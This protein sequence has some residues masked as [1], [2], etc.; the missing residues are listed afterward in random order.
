MTFT[1]GF[2]DPTPIMPSL[3]GFSVHKIPNYSSL[4]ATSVS[5]REL[6]ACQQAYP[7][8]EFN[9]TYEVL[10]DET[11]NE[12]I[13]PEYSALTEFQQITQLFLACSGQYGRFFFEDL[14]DNSRLGQILGT[15]DGVTT[16]FRF[17]RTWGSGALSFEEPVGG[18]NNSKPINV[19]LNGSPTVNY[20]IDLNLQNIE[21]VSAPANGVVIT[22]DFYFYY[23]CRFLE[24][25]NDFEQFYHN[26]WSLKSLKFRSVK[27]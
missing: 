23:F 11:Q 26:L 9:I 10:R 27:N 6:Q 16:V 21:F 2:L 4:V 13:D 8:W 25:I 3:N 1:V 24:D 19:Y 22:A 15:G 18:V 20:N 14:V 5:G 7:L 12:I 17:V